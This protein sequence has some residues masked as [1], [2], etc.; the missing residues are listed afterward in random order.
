MSHAKSRRR[1]ARRPM[2]TMMMMQMGRDPHGDES[3]PFTPYIYTYIL[4]S[5]TPL[6]VLDMC[7]A[8]PKIHMSRISDESRPVKPGD[9]RLDRGPLESRDRGPA[10]DD[11]IKHTLHTTPTHFTTTRLVTLR[12]FGIPSSIVPTSPR[13]HRSRV[14]RRRDRIYTR[15]LPP[16]APSPAR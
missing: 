12:T 14:T 7:R 6:R 11:D 1:R 4:E 8:I 2:M 16:H 5:G 10:R 9:T 13:S 3:R 15:C